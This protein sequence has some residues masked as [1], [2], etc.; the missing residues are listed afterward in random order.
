MVL[1]SREEL[2]T[3]IV[4]Q[5]LTFHGH[6][7]VFTEPV[8][9]WLHLAENAGKVEVGT[10]VVPGSI[11]KL[12]GPWLVVE[13]DLPGILWQLSVTQNATFVNSEGV[14]VRVRADAKEHGFRVEEIID[15]EE[16]EP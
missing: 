9:Y 3:S 15:E 7:G 6:A 11:A 4:R 1:E 12:L 13:R 5:W 2:T 16:S 10:E 14:S 8:H